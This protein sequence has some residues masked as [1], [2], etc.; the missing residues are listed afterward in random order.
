MAVYDNIHFI[1]DKI[2]SHNKA[3]NI[4]QSCRSSGKTTSILKKITKAF[5][6]K[7][8]PSLIL[9][10]RIADI[11]ASYIE[12]M[13]KVINK[14]RGED[15]QIKF[16]YCKG[17]IKSGIVDIYTSL[18]DMKNHTN[19][20]L[21]VIGL[22]APIMRLK[23]GVLNNVRYIMY[24]EFMIDVRSGEKW[25]PDEIKRFREL[26]TTYLREASENIKVW[27]LGNSYSWYSPYHAWLK[28]KASDLSLG[29]L[30]VGSNYTFNLWKPSPELI[31][32]LKQ[33]PMCDL[34]DKYEQYAI[35]GIPVNDQNINICNNLP[36]NFAL[37]TVFRIN[38][39]NLGIYVD[40]GNTDKNIDFTIYVKSI[41]WNPEY[42]RKAMAFNLQDMTS[43]T[44][45]PTKTILNLLLPIKRAM[46]EG[47]IAYQDIGDSYNLEML[48]SVL[49]IL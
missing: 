11:T 24:D 39:I 47:S 41:D 7:G 28:I 29:C 45:I 15:K 5:T 26:Y 49:P 37:F 8:Q 14:F 34:D 9:R 4:V 19:V 46:M 30:L 33:N 2:D 13:E 6:E 10:R 23:G 42:K 3:I 44:F 35:Y 43:A 31:E 22:S 18:L 1:P 25:L 27:L 16:F 40:N 32:L 12:D 38:D 21:R 17:D 48:Y 36:R 20:F